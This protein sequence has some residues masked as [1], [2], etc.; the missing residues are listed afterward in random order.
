MAVKPTKSRRLASIYSISI[1]C[2]VIIGSA[3]ATLPT[4]MVRDQHQ[5]VAFVQIA[6]PSNKPAVIVCKDVTGTDPPE[7][8]KVGLIQLLFMIDS[9][10]YCSS[11]L[12][13]VFT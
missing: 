4:L 2:M 12:F 9:E 8:S 5:N 3:I 11:N 13:T 6:T 7:G 10:I 1:L